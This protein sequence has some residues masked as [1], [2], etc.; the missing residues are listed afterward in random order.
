MSKT[1]STLEP[2]VKKEREE[3]GW[4]DGSVV[5]NISYSSGR[6]TFNSCHP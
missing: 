5:K 2:L 1:P 4:R 6:P 3:K